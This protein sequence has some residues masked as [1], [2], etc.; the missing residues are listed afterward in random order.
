MFDITS[1][2]YNISIQTIA[3]L[4][5]QRSDPRLTQAVLLLVEAADISR[6]PKLAYLA[7]QLSEKLPQAPTDTTGAQP[8][9]R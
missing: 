9:A 6:D 4:T 7:R 5:L 2:R 1:G 3:E 8:P